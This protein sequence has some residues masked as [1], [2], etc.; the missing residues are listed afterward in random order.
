[1]QENE[2][3]NEKEQPTETVPAEVQVSIEPVIPEVLTPSPAEVKEET[4]TLATQP[5]TTN[6]Q[7][8]TNSME[9]HH[10]PHVEKKN[11][12]EYFCLSRRVSPKLFSNQVNLAWTRR[13]ENH[14]A[15]TSSGSRTNQKRDWQKK[16]KC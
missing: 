9:V 12:K 10:H 5:Q 8:Q 7:V 11:F 2:N 1:L 3:T 14:P 15:T 16:E 4:P 6:H 13:N